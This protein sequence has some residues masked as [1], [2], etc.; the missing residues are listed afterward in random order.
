[1]VDLDGDRMMDQ[2]VVPDMVGITVVF[3]GKELP[4]FEVGRLWP[5]THVRAAIG[6][7]MLKDSIPEYYESTI[8]LLSNQDNQTK[9]YAMFLV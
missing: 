1:M 4:M 7:L 9:R 8:F 2:V 3:K 6:I 5:V